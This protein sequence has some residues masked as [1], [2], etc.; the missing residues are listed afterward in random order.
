MVTLNHYP[1]SSTP[2]MPYSFLRMI[3]LVILLVLKLSFYLADK[4]VG[5]KGFQATWTEIKVGRPGKQG[6]ADLIGLGCPQLQ[7]S[8]GI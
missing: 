8:L 2:A 1:H 7:Q 5:A 3:P 4:A 6:L